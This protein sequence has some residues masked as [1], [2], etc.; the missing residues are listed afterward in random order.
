LARAGVAA[1]ANL[2]AEDLHTVGRG[3]G[4]QAS[5]HGNENLGLHFSKKKQVAEHKDTRVCVS[6]LILMPP[7]VPINHCPYTPNTIKKGKKTLF[8]YSMIY[9][10]GYNSGFE[11][12]NFSQ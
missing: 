2:I 4:H 11:H 1:A 8:N 5:E 9:C 10:M 7:I 6:P 3:N 12:S